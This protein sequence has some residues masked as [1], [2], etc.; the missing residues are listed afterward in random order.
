[1]TLSPD[2]PLVPGDE[3]LLEQLFINLIENAIKYSDG[4]L[5]IAA[6]FSPTEVAVELNDRGPGIPE[7]EQERIFEKFHRSGREGG[8]EGVGLGL[9]ICRAIV[10]VHGGQISASNRRGGGA[11]FRFTLPLEG[12]PEPPGVEPAAADSE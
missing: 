3:I 1:V 5:E 10:A 8:R 11:S 12:A 9:A 6:T 4:P 2:A 7:G